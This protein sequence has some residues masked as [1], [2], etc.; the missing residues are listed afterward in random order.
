MHA[1]RRLKLKRN[2]KFQMYSDP[3][4][5]HSLQ[6]VP[7]NEAALNPHLA[8]PGNYLTVSPLS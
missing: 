7:G 5:G 6:P 2:Y 4:K 3:L 8:L 1:R